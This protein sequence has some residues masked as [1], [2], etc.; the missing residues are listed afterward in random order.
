MIARLYS[1]MIKVEIL[2]I[3]CIMCVH[4]L[5]VIPI[6]HHEGTDAY[7]QWQDNDRYVWHSAVVTVTG[8]NGFRPR[9]RPSVCSPDK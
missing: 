2:E 5:G 3:S 8:S 7:I 6:F 9:E 1:L 4:A